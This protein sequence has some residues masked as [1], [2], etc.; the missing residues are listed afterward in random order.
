MVEWLT[1]GVRKITGAAFT[2]EP[3]PDKITK[4]L[5]ARVE[6]KRKALGLT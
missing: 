6:E 5:V 4:A 1:E 3:D 2:V